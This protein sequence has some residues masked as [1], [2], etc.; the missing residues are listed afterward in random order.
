MLLLPPSVLSRPIARPSTLA[1]TILRT[2]P[3]QADGNTAYTY[4]LLGGGGCCRGAGVS[5]SGEY[6]QHVD[7]KEGAACANRCSAE[8]NCKGCDLTQH[9]GC[10]VYFEEITHVTANLACLCFLCYGDG[11]P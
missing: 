5:N 8:A 4:E 3:A 11:A 10:K 9:G 6:I 2:T 7:V 1:P